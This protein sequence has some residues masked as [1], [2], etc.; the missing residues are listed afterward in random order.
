MTPATLDRT[1]SLP[2]LARAWDWSPRKLHRLCAAHAIPHLRIR[3]RIYFEVS[4]VE[5]WKAARRYVETAR[6][7]PPRAPAAVDECAQLGIPTD[8]LFS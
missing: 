2:A 3:G 5:A 7:V 4:T 8:H 1:L 6:E